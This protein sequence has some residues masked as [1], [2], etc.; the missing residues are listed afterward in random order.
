M[1]SKMIDETG[2]RS[3]NNVDLKIERALHLLA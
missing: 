2:S 1:I 3:L